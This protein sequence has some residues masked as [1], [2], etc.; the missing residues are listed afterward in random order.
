MWT[1]E[2][3]SQGT[4]CLLNDNKL[5]AGKISQYFYISWDLWSFF[6]FISSPLFQ[7][8]ALACFEMKLRFDG[9]ANT[10][11]I[12]YMLLAGPG[13]GKVSVL[14]ALIGALYCALLQDYC[15]NCCG[16]ITLGM[17][18]KRLS[19]TCRYTYHSLRFLLLCWFIWQGAR[20]L[21]ELREVC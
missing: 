18:E 4:E 9:E 3:K 19:Y 6:P 14:L 2:T 8:V 7:F 20:H 1:E 16:L 17:T 10:H 11:L 5:E 21:E 15:I 12:A 13:G